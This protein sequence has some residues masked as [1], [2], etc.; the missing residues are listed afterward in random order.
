MTVAE[1]V[2]AAT[3]NALADRVVL[4]TGASGGLGGAISRQAAATGATLILCGR[5]VRP[6]E[7]LYDE[8]V[9]A[10]GAQPA[11]YPIDL[12]GATPADYQE[13][14]ESIEREFGRLDGLVHAAAHFTGLVAHA[15]TPPEEWLKALQVN[16]NAPVALTHACLPVL[17]RSDDA[18]VVA[19]LDDN[20][21]VGRAHWGAYGV[22][23]FALRGL[24]SQ[25]AA[26]WDNTPVRV[27]GL[28]PTPMRTALRA[29]AYFAENPSLIAFPDAVAAAT[30]ELLSANGKEWR[31]RIRDLNV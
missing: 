11:I 15:L 14:A 3:S 5:R 8:I 20:D 2:A 30:V 17:K 10:G 19:V 4:V 27:S 24:I 18:V 7:K 26:E 22:A 12:E 29:R 6:L 1:P 28:V 16:L 13:L 23:K 31:G 9:A 21:R 25:W